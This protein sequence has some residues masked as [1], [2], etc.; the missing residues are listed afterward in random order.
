GT[1]PGERA[2]SPSRT[3][4][5]CGAETPPLEPRLFSFNSPHGACPECEGLGVR[6]SASPASVVRDP[7]LSIRAGALAVTLASK[8]GLLFPR[9]DFRF[10]ERVA[11]A[12]RFDLD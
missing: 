5:G 12:H 6:L 2:S 9:V 8:R 10:L 7:T 3:C 4:P 1:E 11:R